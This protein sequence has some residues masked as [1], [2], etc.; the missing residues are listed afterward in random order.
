VRR[1]ETVAE[2]RSLTI[3]KTNR[4]PDAAPKLAAPRA[5]YFAACGSAP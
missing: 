1:K 5:L 2:G 4:C 3:H